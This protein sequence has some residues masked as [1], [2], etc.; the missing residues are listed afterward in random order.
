MAT[1]QIHH[2]QVSRKKGPFRSA[3]AIIV[4]AIATE[5]GC[6]FGG[7]IGLSTVCGQAVSVCMGVAPGGLI[8]VYNQGGVSFAPKTRVTVRFR[9]RRVE[10]S[11]TLP[12]P[13][14]VLLEKKPYTMTAGLLSPGGGAATGGKMLS[15]RDMMMERNAQNDMRFNQKGVP[16]STLTF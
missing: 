6:F 12:R 7:I 3:L 8:V 9:S 15:K 10:E 5:W 13:F 1:A 11:A 4:D 14:H 2:T 16:N